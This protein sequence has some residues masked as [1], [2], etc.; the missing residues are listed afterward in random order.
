MM[1]EKFGGMYDG[2]EPNGGAGE[3]EPIIGDQGASAS[4][5][6]NTG[7]P[8]KAAEFSI[9]TE[10]AEKGYAKDI[11]SNEDLWKKL[12]G[13]QSLLG[14]PKEGGVPVEGS[15]QE[16]WDAFY[17]TLGKPDAAADY[18][19]NRE[20]LNQ[21][22]VKDFANDELDNATKD[23]FHKANLTQEQANVLQPEFEKL[24]EGIHL[25]GIEKFN[26][27]NV[28]FDEL[29]QKTFGEK[30]EEVMQSAKQLIA[31][32]SPEGFEE[33]IKELP[34]ESLILMAGVLNSIKGKY[35]S[36]DSINQLNNVGSGASDEIGLRTEA[37]KILQ[38]EPYRDSFHPD[39]DKAL[40]EVAAIYEKIGKMG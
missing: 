21:D 18:S 17:K 24:M 20:G 39:H 25:Q 34:N 36:E 23:I 3:G 6:Q 35:I 26:A 7:D 12:D 8:V 5:S 9:P 13:S 14:K 27:D 19:F 29:A 16:T 15:T 2:G 4:V 32:N 10:Y 40:K 31:E 28:S 22:F 30:E 38:S 11:K 1:I 37:R 33:H